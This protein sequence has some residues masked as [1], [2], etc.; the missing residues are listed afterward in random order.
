MKRANSVGGLSM[1]GRLLFAAILSSLCVCPAW[2]AAP[3]PPPTAQVDLFVTDYQENPS[4]E[5]KPLVDRAINYPNPEEVTVRAGGKTFTYK[6]PSAVAVH[7]G[8]A[9][10]NPRQARLS[11][12]PGQ[13][14]PFSFLLRPKENLEEVMIA[15]G[16]LRGPGGSIA[17][18]GVVVTSVEEFHGGGRQILMTLGK[19]WNMSAHATEYFWCTVKVPGDARPGV[20]SGEALVTSKGAKVAALS[21]L[22]DVLPIRLEDPP[23]AL[24]LNYSSPKDKRRLEIQLADMRAHGMTTVAPLYNFHLPVYDQDTSELGEFIEAYKQAGF[25]APLY[26]ASPMDLELS[27]LAGYGSVDSRRFQQKYIRV[28]RTL[29]EEVRKHGVPTVMSI[30]DELTNRGVEGVRIAGKL[31]RLTAEELPEIAST[32][33]MNG[34][35]E[36]LAMAPWL[37][38]ATFN[39]G[40][41]GADHHNQG[42]HLLNRRFLEEL[43]AKTGAIPW[44]VNAGVG[45]LPFGLFLW[46]MSK[47]GVRGKVEWYY[48]LGSNERGSLVRVDGT[49]VW[50][51]LDYERS[52]EGIT[53]LRY[54][55]TL[56][57]LIARAK[58]AR[59]AA[60]EV[61]AAEAA[62]RRI[63]DA[64]ADDWTI[65]DSG[66]R[67]SID[68]LGVVDAEKAAA[69]GQFDATRD[70]VAQQILRLQAAL[71]N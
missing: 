60:A 21:I 44:F 51:T 15:G 40:W 28:M 49:N 50:P 62:L 63:F 42:R 18:A 57:K 31:A 34:Y 32:S 19:P 13:Y 41:D 52:R 25:P 37:N 5:Q 65:Y 33:D 61:Q 56:E 16:E 54:L 46:K 11:A 71:G 53:D 35:R 47:L 58:A 26:F 64:L 12:A 22:L 69:L 43:Q 1:T 10:K 39:N 67:F 66:A 7:P 24:G 27:A 4:P 30:G 45:R 2:A 36:V 8:S 38:I 29:D 14:V 70:A 9:G 48:S 55:V 17:P 59:K 6:A 23:L 68:G 20:Y 3:S